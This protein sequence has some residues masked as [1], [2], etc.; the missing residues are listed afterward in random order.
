[1]IMITAIFVPSAINAIIV[2]SIF[3]I[4]VFARVAPPNALFIWPCE[5]IRAA[6]AAGKNKARITVEHILPN[7]SNLLLVQGT[8]HFARGILAEADLS[9]VGL[10]TQPP[11]P[12][13]GLMLFNAQTLMMVSP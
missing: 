13:W 6:R 11:M 3:N 9:Y 2:I 8:I 12:S 5:Y 4:P 1:M 7:I 10:A